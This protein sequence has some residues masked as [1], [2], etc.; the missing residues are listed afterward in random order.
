VVRI[1]FCLFAE[2]I[3]LLPEKVFTDLVRHRY[4]D[5]TPEQFTRSLRTLFVAMREGNSMFGAHIIPWFNGGLFEDDFVPDLPGGSLHELLTACDQDWAGIDPSIFGTC[6]MHHEKAPQLD[7]TP[8][9]RHSA[10]RQAGAH[11]PLRANGA[12]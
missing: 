6:S 7:I 11:N 9:G 3:G 2:D 12:S 5:Q 4:K 8:Q 1:L 10:G